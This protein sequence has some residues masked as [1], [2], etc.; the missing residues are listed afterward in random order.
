MVG[1]EVGWVVT[2]GSPRELERS[3]P[4]FPPRR[5]PRTAG[6]RAPD[7]PPDAS[8]SAAPKVEPSSALLVLLAGAE[9]PKPP[10]AG[11]PNEAEAPPKLGAGAGA[12]NDP[13]Y[14]APKAPADDG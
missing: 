1:V 11:A 7:E 8:S 14:A 3:A 10:D 4:Y 13:P 6:R 5:R 9:L 12:P 2:G